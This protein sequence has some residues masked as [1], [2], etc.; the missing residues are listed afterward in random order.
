MIARFLAAPMIVATGALLVAPPAHADATYDLVLTGLVEHTVD[1]WESVPLC[2]GPPTISYPWTGMLTVVVDSS[3]DGTYTNAAFES[4]TLTS[5]VAGGTWDAD[6]TVTVG[7]HRVTAVAGD[8]PVMT[9]HDEEAFI[10]FD[11]LDAT[12]AGSGMHHYGPTTASG[13]LSPVPEAR[14]DL[15]LL[16]GLAALATVAL[17]RRGQACIKGQRG[18]TSNA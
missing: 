13:S 2:S 7:G 18:F 10:V 15:S 6:F 3:A 8:L 12:F 17:R 16:F 9:A 11:G 1:C 14:A 4:L 5:N